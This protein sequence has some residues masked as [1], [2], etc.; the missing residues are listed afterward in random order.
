ML[1]CCLLPNTIH[2]LFYSFQSNN[3][4]INKTLYLER[5]FEF[6]VNLTP[7]IS[8]FVWV[9]FLYYDYYENSLCKNVNQ[10]FM[11]KFL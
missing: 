2:I 8:L 5:K 6:N 4:L 10:N 11:V 1:D 9:Y 3:R 7:K